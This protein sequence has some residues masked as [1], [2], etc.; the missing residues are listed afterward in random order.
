MSG[1]RGSQ[2]GSGRGL[3]W[4]VGVEGGGEGGREGE[5]SLVGRAGRGKNGCKSGEAEGRR[6]GEGGIC[7]L[8]YVVT[9]VSHR[10]CA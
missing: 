9:G 8:S 3:N 7:V 4:Q 1:V 10:D 5:G 6:R 2:K